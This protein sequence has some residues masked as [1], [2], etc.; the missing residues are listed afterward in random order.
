MKMRKIIISPNRTFYCK[1]N[2][3]ENLRQIKG[4]AGG[5]M[6]Y[7]CAGGAVASCVLISL[8]P[9]F[10]PL[11]HSVISVGENTHKSRPNFSA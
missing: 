10:S 4:K 6:I 5:M 11:L 8:S 2:E 9:P 1:N 7:L 3:L